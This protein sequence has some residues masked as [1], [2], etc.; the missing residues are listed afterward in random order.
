[1]KVY[2][3]LFKL[4]FMNQ[5]QYRMAA[6]AGIS[7]QF[8]FGIVYIMVYLAFYT[9]SKDASLPMK[10]NELVCYLWL[11]QSLFALIN[12]WVKDN[13]LLSM[14]KDGNIAYELCRPIDFYKKWYATMY[15]NRLAS[16]TLRFLPIIIVAILLPEP[17]KL[18]PPAS[19]TSFILFLLALLISSL[20]ITAIAMLYHSITIFTLD[21]KGIMSLLMVLIEIFSGGTIPLVFF[22]KFLKIIAYILPFRYIIDLPFRVYSGNISISSAIPSIG[23]SIL[24]LIIIITI[25]YILSKKA[26]NKAT[27]Q[28]G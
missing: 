18:L 25:G 1:M 23:L 28:G 11:G 17:Y 8:F 26:C 14:I 21:E 24:W 2:L 9:S 13:D 12:P 5:L 4:K 10:W 20:L 15:G 6:I 3:N 22:P 16:V 7:T 27:V 19:I